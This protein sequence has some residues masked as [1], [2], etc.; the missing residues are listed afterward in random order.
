MTYLPEQLP[1]MD[2]GWTFCSDIHAYHRN[3]IAYGLRPFDD[4]THMN[5]SI[6]ANWNRRVKEDGNV[7]C[8]GDLVFAEIDGD[9]GRGRIRDFLSGVNGTIWLVPGNHDD[10]LVKLYEEGDEIVTSKVKLLSPYVDGWLG[11]QRV[12]LCHYPLERWHRSVS[13]VHLHGHTHVRVQDDKLIDPFGGLKNVERRINLCSDVLAHGSNIKSYAPIDW[14]TLHR[15]I[16][17]SCVPQCSP[18]RPELYC[19]GSSASTC[20]TTPSSSKC[21]STE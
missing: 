2:K 8:L 11:T 12:V 20:T 15:L 18:D 6:K 10:L 3:I 16:T 19:G 5:D 9:N 4:V 13:T 21:N 1:R 17:R 14:D 7:L